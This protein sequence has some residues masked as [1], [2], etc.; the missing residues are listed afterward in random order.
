MIGA[1]APAPLLAQ[2]P[3]A[4]PAPA[5]L[6]QPA[7]LR[8]F[9][10]EAM[11]IGRIEAIEKVELRARVTGFL[12]APLFGDG[13]R[14]K[15][16]Q[17]LFE[18]EPEP[19]QATVDQRAAQLASAKATLLNAELQLA[20]AEELIKTNATSK[21]VVDERTAA[22][23]S[24]IAGVQGAEAA[25]T[26][27]RIDLSYTRIASPIDG[28]IG[29]SA[30]TQGNL[31][32]PESGVLATIVRDDEVYAAFS[33]SQREILEGRR[34]GATLGGTAFLIM[35]DGS[36]YPHE[37]RLDFLDVVVDP[38]TDARLAR[39]VFPN[40]EHHLADGQ[41]VRVRYEQR[42][43]ERSVAIPQQAIAVDQTGTFVFV[44]NPQNVVERR[45]VTLGAQR[46]GYAAVKEGV[47]DG[48]L[49]IVQGHQRVRP[50]MTVTAQRNPTPAN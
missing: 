39:A 21:A 41:T 2:A 25:L 40:P 15:A 18:I 3:A 22:R 47:S 46:G 45:Q 19:F 20:R 32:G 5:V 16:G 33:V 9:A 11:F 17:V 44:V 6:V 34:S 43:Q 36:T 24:A 35:A 48:E 50:G 29:R 31:V 1:L 49:V 38:R 14:V 13:E 10:Q 7:E 8:T 26:Q 4:R 28:R 27:A 30:F 37:G 42:T 12:K 23:D